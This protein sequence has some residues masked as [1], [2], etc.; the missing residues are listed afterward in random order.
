MKSREKRVASRERITH[1]LPDGARELV[2]D[3][4]RYLLH[5]CGR[6]GGDSYEMIAELLCYLPEVQ[7]MGGRLQEVSIDGY[8]YQFFRKQPQRPFFDALLAAE[9][10]DSNECEVMLLR[11]R[12]QKRLEAAA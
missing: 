12:F 6:S 7:F 2:M 3:V 4:C 1:P 10:W 11:Y 8:H 5:F 9:A